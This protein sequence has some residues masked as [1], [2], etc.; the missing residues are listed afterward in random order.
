MDRPGDHDANRRTHLFHGANLHR[1]RVRAQQQAL[2][3]RLR[4]LAG[5]EQRVLRIARRMVRRKIQRLEV[6]V[7][8]F[9]DGAFRNGIAE[10][11][12][13]TDDFAHRTD[14]GM[15]GADGAAYAGEGDVDA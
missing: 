7:I 14:D 15:L 1:R 6:V 8:G 10:F 3:L 5:D 4:L 12:K 9:D 13:D 2:A 11:L